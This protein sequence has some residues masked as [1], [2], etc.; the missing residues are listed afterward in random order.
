[1]CQGNLGPSAWGCLGAFLQGGGGFS[2]AEVEKGVFS[3]RAMLGRRFGRSS[4]HMGSFRP[5]FLL[6]LLLFRLKVGIPGVA[7]ITIKVIVVPGELRERIQDVSSR[8]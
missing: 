1:M 4:G 8:P 5:L 3:G 2:R 6:L 7:W